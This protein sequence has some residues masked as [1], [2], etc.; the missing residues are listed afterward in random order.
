[1]ELEKDTLKKLIEYLKAHGYPENSFAVEYKIGNFRVDLAIIDP[2]TKIPIL[3]FEIKSQNNNLNI[4]FGRNQLLKYLTDLG[5]STVPTY[6]VFPIPY[7]PFFEIKRLYFNVE[8]EQIVEKTVLD[9]TEFDFI[10]QKR[11]R[12][13]ERVEKNQKKTEDTIDN[14]KWFCWG[15]A[16][17]ILFIG[18]LKKF[19][20]IDID[21]TDLALGG[22]LFG[23]VILP[24]ASKLKFLGMEFERF[25]KKN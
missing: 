3:L 22:A 10:M 18:I 14:F 17:L 12:I 25:E 1:M 5:D 6:L 20:V 13:S 11:A 2:E 8:N 23:L 15:L 19:K 16:L 21:A 7:N 4:K 24:F 9:E